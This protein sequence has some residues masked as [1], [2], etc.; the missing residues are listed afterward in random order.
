MGLC[1]HS[2]QHVSIARGRVGL[3]HSGDGRELVGHSAQRSLRDFERDERLHS[4]SRRRQIDSRLVALD[5]PGVFEFLQP[6][7]D[8]R[9]GDV[10][11]P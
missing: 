6:R 2:A 10:Q 3:K 1:G 4:K 5:Y 9:P 7:L 11:V 8:R